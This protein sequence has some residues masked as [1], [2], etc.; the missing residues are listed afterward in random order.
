MAYSADIPDVSIGYRW[1]E[2]LLWIPE[3]INI[4]TDRFKVD[5]DYQEGQFDDIPVV[6]TQLNDP[7]DAMIDSSLDD[8]DRFVFSFGITNPLHRADA[9]NP[10]WDPPR[11]TFTRSGMFVPM[12]DGDDNRRPFV[13]DIMASIAQACSTR[14]ALGLRPEL[15][16]LMF[17]L[18]TLTIF[19]G[20]SYH[21][22]LTDGAVK[23]PYVQCDSESE[24]LPTPG[25]SVDT[26]T[27]RFYP[28]GGLIPACGTMLIAQ[29]ISSAHQFLQVIMSM[30]GYNPPVSLWDSGPVDR[31]MYSLSQTLGNHQMQERRQDL[32]DSV[33]RHSPS[34]SRSLGA[35]GIKYLWDLPADAQS[36]SFSSFPLPPGV[37]P[38]DPAANL[39]HNTGP[40]PFGVEVTLPT[41]RPLIAESD[42]SGAK[43]L[44]IHPCALYTEGFQSA[45]LVE[46]LE[47]IVLSDWTVV[48]RTFHVD[49]ATHSY[50]VRLFLRN[51]RQFNHHFTTV[52][53]G[54][55]PPIA[56][57]RD[58]P[59]LWPLYFSDA[60]LPAQTGGGEQ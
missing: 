43:L 58:Y 47:Q 40:P 30:G 60:T 45:W 53:R 31:H 27:R 35:Q 38:Q 25:T 13:P 33:S 11:I 5:H 29:P 50:S 34:W 54:L 41:G 44:N 52:P 57:Y 16:H 24:M 28:W 49:T 19:A 8:R 3:L 42:R 6:H 18:R 4:S 12:P 32:Q 14:F 36:R 23:R 46:M 22:C 20:D 39:R 7:S 26:F 15:A 55:R 56:V 21:T 10:Y 17:E 37:H 1:S 9:F 59:D 51:K 2:S 48:F